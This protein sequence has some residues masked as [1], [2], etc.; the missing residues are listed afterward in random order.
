M[1]TDKAPDVP[2]HWHELYIEAQSDPLDS[3]SDTKFCEDIKLDYST[4]Q[5]WK[6][7]YRK[8]IF[9]EVEKRRQHYRNELR[10]KGHKALARKLDK[11]TNA[12]KLLFQ[13]LG[14]LVEKTETK[15][16]MSDADKARRLRSLLDQNTK[17]Q[18]EWKIADPG[19]S[20][21]GAG[22]LPVDS[23]DVPGND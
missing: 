22:E 2:R 18:A 7:R 11:D 5:T 16:E 8:Y 20:L 4:F 21:A 12:I 15:M 9:G 1:S 19:G 6:H 3:R 14:D 17:K 10:A 23:P 13:L